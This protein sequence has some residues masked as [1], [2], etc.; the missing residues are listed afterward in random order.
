MA[1]KSRHEACASLHPTRCLPVGF[2]GVK[3]VLPSQ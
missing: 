2:R 3:M 1:I